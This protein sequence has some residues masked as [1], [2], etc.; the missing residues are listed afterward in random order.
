MINRFT[1]LLGIEGLEQKKIWKLYSKINKQ[2][3]LSTLNPLTRLACS[4]YIIMGQAK[5][6]CESVSIVCKVSEH[7]IL[8]STEL[9]LQHIILQ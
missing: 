8:R 2:P 6:N 4:I 9:V 7:T 1:S 5:K 3:E